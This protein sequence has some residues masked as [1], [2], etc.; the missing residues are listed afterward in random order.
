[1][2]LLCRLHVVSSTVAVMSKLQTETEINYSVCF[3]WVKKR[4]SPTSNVLDNVLISEV[5]LRLALQ[6]GK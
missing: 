2:F 3:H 6:G 5:R 1:M 4:L